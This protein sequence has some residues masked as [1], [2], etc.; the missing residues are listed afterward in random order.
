MGVE[1]ASLEAT[2]GSE[3]ATVG[4][5]EFPAPQEARRVKAAK[6]GKMVFFIFVLP[7]LIALVL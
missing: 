2:V 5:E 3:E 6:A 7:L 4:S 1:S